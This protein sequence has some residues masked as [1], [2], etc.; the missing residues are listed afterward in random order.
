MQEN[1]TAPCSL[2]G[3][4]HCHLRRQSRQLAR[5]RVNPCPREVVSTRGS[6]PSSEIKIVEVQGEQVSPVMESDRQD[7]DDRLE[8]EKIKDARRREKALKNDL[9]IVRTQLAV[10]E[11]KLNAAAREIAAAKAANRKT[12]ALHIAQLVNLRED[13]SRLAQRLVEQERE[14]Q[15]DVAT[16][17]AALSDESRAMRGAAVRC[18]VVGLV[19][20]RC[21]SVHI[22]SS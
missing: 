9:A 17:K 14:F 22:F 21:S 5:V 7:V 18:I 6:L 8:N 15:E 11:E 12:N 19:H 3:S 1:L 4:V 10:K 20:V 16:I 2:D 13:V